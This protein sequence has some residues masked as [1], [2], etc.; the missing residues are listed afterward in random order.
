MTLEAIKPEAIVAACIAVG[1]VIW[2]VIA[3]V[4]GMQ[5]RVQYLEIELLELKMATAK[6][7]EEI[8]RAQ[9]AQHKAMRSDLKDFTIASGARDAAIERK[10]DELIVRLMR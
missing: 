1:G 9:E 2:K 4:F 3:M 8:K 7:H 5:R 10:L 6:Q